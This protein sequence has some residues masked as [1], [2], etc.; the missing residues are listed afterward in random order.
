MRSLPS[1]MSLQQLRKRALA[2]IGAKICVGKEE[3]LTSGFQR[4]DC[5]HLVIGKELRTLPFKVLWEVNGYLL[6][7]KDGKETFSAYATQR[8]ET[9]IGELSHLATFRF[10]ITTKAQTRIQRNEPFS[11][12]KSSSISIH[13]PCFLGGG[14]RCTGF[15]LGRK[16]FVTKKRIDLLRVAIDGILNPAEKA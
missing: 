10:S 15:L 16:R 13:P 5:Y 4:D 12:S 2:E 1:C 3:L 6:K 7:V 9:Y 11:D 8:L 14:P